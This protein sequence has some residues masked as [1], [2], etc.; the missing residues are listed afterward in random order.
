MTFETNVSLGY[1]HVVRNG[2][3]INTY[4]ISQ[5]GILL[6]QVSSNVIDPV[7]HSSLQII[8]DVESDLSLSDEEGD[9]QGENISTSKSGKTGLRI[10]YTDCS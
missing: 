6:L 8:H 4:G 9:D 2:N 5:K 1:Q 10:L 3:A 7:N